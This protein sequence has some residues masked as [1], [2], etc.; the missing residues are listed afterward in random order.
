MFATYLMAAGR[1]RGSFVA[2]A[3]TDVGRGS[4]ASTPE[5]RSRGPSDTV[6]GTLPLSP[7]RNAG[8]ACSAVMGRLWSIPSVY[9]PRA[10]CSMNSQKGEG[11]DGMA[12]LL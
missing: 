5:T 8:P 11:G 4:A 3:E 2:A 6:R 1:V 9:K 12:L 10:K 7:N